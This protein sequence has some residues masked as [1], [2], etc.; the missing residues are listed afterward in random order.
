MAQPSPYTPGEVAH[1]VVGRREQLAFYRERA[2]FISRLG[3]L[4]ARVRVDHAAR[5]IGKTSLLRE[6]ERIMR[7]AGVRTLWVTANPDESLARTVLAKLPAVAGD[8]PSRARGLA[9]L[10][11]SATLTLGV[12]GVVTASVGVKRRDEPLPASAAE[13][14]KA[15][16]TAATDAIADDGGSGL[17]IFLDEIQSADP[18][19]L[20]VIAYAW[21]ELASERPDTPAGIFA[22]GLP[23]SA[24]TISAAVTFAERF[25]YRAL[26][27]LQD[28]DVALALVMPAQELRVQWMPDAL[29]LGVESARGFPYKVQ[30]IGH[31]AWAAAGRPDPGGAIAEGHVRQGLTVVDDQMRELFRARW[32]A[33]TRAERGVLRAMAR[34]GGDD[35]KREDLAAELNVSSRAISGARARLI[36]KGIIEATRFGYVSFTVPGFAEYILASDGPGAD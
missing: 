7:A 33:A 3:R 16:I 36:R 8:G 34:L 9:R 17:A 15:A 12:P 6:G 5:G 30:L 32:G 1:S 31:E 22:A 2:E 23:S 24:E 27:T 11:E 29:R 28:S 18:E 20:R 21:Q 14:F 19:S 25:E 26:P 10:V 35:V 13:A 4:A